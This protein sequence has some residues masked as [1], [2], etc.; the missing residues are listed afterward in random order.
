MESALD[1][2]DRI[3]DVLERRS[4]LAVKADRPRI[5]TGSRVVFHDVGLGDGP[6]HRAAAQHKH[7]RSCGGICDT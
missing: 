3:F 6:R 1:Q 4:A 2:R 7:I 5:S